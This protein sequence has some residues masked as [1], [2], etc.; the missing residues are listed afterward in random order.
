MGSSGSGGIEGGCSPWGAGGERKDFLAAD[1]LRRAELEPAARS[2][3]KE[4]VNGEIVMLSA[5]YIVDWK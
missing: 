1:M 4:N 5:I 3:I 2:M